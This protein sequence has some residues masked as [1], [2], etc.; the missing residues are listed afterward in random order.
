MESQD[1]PAERNS[2][3]RTAWAKEQQAKEVEIALD[4]LNDALR[5]GARLEAQLVKKRELRIVDEETTVLEGVF[6]D[7]GEA[8]QVLVDWRSFL[9]LN[10]VLKLPT[11]ER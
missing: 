11:L 4:I 9:R 3:Q 8:A 7:A 6:V 10:P 2:R 1:T 5:P